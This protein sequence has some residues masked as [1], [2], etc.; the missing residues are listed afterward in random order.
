MAMEYGLSYVSSIDP[1][2]DINNLH[3]KTYAVLRSIPRANFWQFP[4]VGI[5]G[6]VSQINWNATVPDVETYLNRRCYVQLGFDITFTGV[7][8]GVG[9]TLLQCAGYAAAPGIS[10]GNT[11]ATC[12]SLRCLPL[13][14]LFQTFTVTINNNAITQPLG[15]Y[16]R[17]FQRFQRTYDDQN[18]DLSMS[19]AAP[20][21]SFDY[22]D[23]F[24]SY[25]NPQGIYGGN[26]Y[27]QRGAFTGVTIIRNDSTGVADVAIARVYL[28]EPFWI[29]PF[30]FDR[31]DE[32]VSM[33]GIR[34]FNVSAICGGRGSG[35]L[36]GQAGSLWSHANGIPG[37]SGAITNATVN[38][39]SANLFLNFITPP[40]GQPL[41]RSLYYSWVN[42]SYYQQSTPSVLAGA[43]TSQN[44]Q[45]IQ[46]DTVP[47]RMY[48]WMD[49]SDAAMDMT[50]TDTIPFMTTNVAIRWD[51]TSNI[52]ADMTTNDLYQMTVKNGFNC[53][54]NQANGVQVFP[55]FAAA[56][57]R[58][59]TGFI[60]CI[61]FG[62]DL[63]LPAGQ[64][65]GLAGR[66]TMQIRVT[67]TNLSSATVTNASVNVL[68]V[69]EGVMF[70]D[71][72]T[73]QFSSGVVSQNEVK[74]TEGMRPISHM[75][76][77]NILGGA[78]WDDVLNFVKR[79]GPGV[80]RA[81][82]SYLPAPAQQVGEAVLGAYGK[83]MVGGAVVGGR[84][85]GRL[86]Q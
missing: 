25:L 22:K 79:A 75:P 17:I 32:P 40:E 1:R 69:E 28:V 4:S 2:V 44:S 60:L 61:N 85:L 84:T 71:N 36:A 50:Q 49:K 42:P 83:G 11:S 78:F 18:L 70:I 23:L 6:S 26:T 66:H 14:Q 65:P 80:F 73:I 67:A 24:G 12:D 59:G 5:L 46:L 47:S 58:S 57:Y 29:S 86:M 38:F 56:P 81:L 48:I 31:N 82:K 8:A 63:P 52:L 21:Q 77:K 64:C 53:T 37:L 30:A 39:T 15:L 62:T 51:T 45:T 54:W 76:S 3:N 34:N 41:P 7:S 55:A 19:P 10:A 13:S 68:I 33:I 74:M 72:Q 20:D 9:M 16:S 27:D 43:S 35:P